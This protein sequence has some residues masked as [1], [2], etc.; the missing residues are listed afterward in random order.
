[1]IAK[2]TYLI[3]SIKYTWNKIRE[4]IKYSVIFLYKHLKY[5]YINQRNHDGQTNR[6]IWKQI[7]IYNDIYKHVYTSMYQTI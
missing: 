3:K 4:Y 1:M 2:N 5:L 6:N 7:I